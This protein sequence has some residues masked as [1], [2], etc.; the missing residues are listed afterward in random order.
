MASE[1][2]LISSYDPGFHNRNMESTVVRLNRESQWKDLSCI[3]LI[4]ASG[5]ISTRVVSSWLGLIK[6]PNNKCHHIFSVE[7]EVGE[8]YN[9]MLQAI[10]NDSNLSQWKYVLCMEHDNSPPGDGLVKLLT[11]M[12]AHTEMA[13]IGGLYFTKGFGGVAQIWGNPSEEVNFRPQ[14]PDSKGGLIECCGTGMGFTVFRLEMFKDSRLRRPWFKT[15]N[16]SEGQGV[17]TQDLYFWG[18]ARKF[19]YRCAVDCSVK[20]GHYDADSDM[21]W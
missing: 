11:Q 8:A 12:E 4:P 2:K 7:A 13:A 14:L 3:I 18:D 19:G 16:G 21:M 15:L 6:P 5:K 1:P 10:L 9:S 17:G 20:V